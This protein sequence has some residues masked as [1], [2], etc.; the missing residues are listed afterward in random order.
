MMLAIVMLAIAPL[1]EGLQVCSRMQPLAGFHPPALRVPV[2]VAGLY[3]RVDGDEGEVDVAKVN[4]LL[5]ERAELRDGRDFDAADEVRDELVGMGVTVLDKDRVWYV[6]DRPKGFREQCTYTRQAG[7]DIEVDVEKVEELIMERAFLRRNRDFAG[8]DE[9]R[10]AL[11]EIGVRV[12]D[13]EYEWYAMR[14]RTA[15][16]PRER[17]FGPL[18]HD[19]TRAADDKAKLTEEATTEI[20]ELIRKRLEAKMARRW[21][22]AATRPP[23]PARRHPP[24]AT[25]HLP[26]VRGSMRPPLPCSLFLTLPP[27]RERRF[28]EADVHYNE[29]KEKYNVSVYDGRTKSWRADGGNW[30]PP[31][32]KRAEGDVG[33]VDMD[34]VTKLLEAR[35][36]ARRKRDYAAAD[37]LRND[38]QNLGIF[39]DDKERTWSMQRPP[40]S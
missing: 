38:L 11:A 8:A 28:E 13:K 36:D 20:N 2:L 33:E 14:K 39:V 6:G 4:E 26:L 31:G 17:N 18:G 9:V 30:A 37:S 29:L 10:D 24:A 3:E 32:Y 1:V 40:R 16:P 25:R 21:P 23:P 19:Y 35:I 27:R 34:A 5:E 7:N 15:G 12:L 22:P